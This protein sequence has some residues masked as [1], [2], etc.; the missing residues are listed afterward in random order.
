MVNIT[1]ILD[2]RDSPWV[3][4]P[5]RTVI[6]CAEDIDKEKFR[7]IVGAFDNGKTE[8]TPYE[9]EARRRGLDVARIHEKRSFDLG[10]LKKVIDVVRYRGV[11]IIHTHDFRSNVLGILA[12][13]VTRRSVVT[14]VHGWI[15]NNIKARV[16]AAFDKLLLRHFDHIIAVSE[17]TMN[18]IG[19]LS[20]QRCTIIHNSLRLQNYKLL[21]PYGKFREEFKLGENEV[22]IAHIGR[23]SREKGQRLFLETA[24]EISRKTF[25][26]RFILFGVGPDREELERIVNNSELKKAVLFAG[27]RNDMHLIY[28]DIDLVVQ[29]SYTEGMPNVILESLLME[30]PVIATNVGGTVEVVKHGETGILIEP[31]NLNNIIENITLFIQDRS[32]YSDMAR[33]GRLDIIHRF[34]HEIRV[35]RLMEVYESIVVNKSN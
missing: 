35:K 3:D 23:L 11:D 25:G 32:R 24:R 33:R 27:Y 14:T 18:Q 6:E 7:I 1:K 22:V 19:E 12:A 13:K 26:V 28:N 10:V 16:F 31:N 4:G 8:G 5:G 17:N 29:T 30:V 21:R 34:D 9:Q 2:L 20:G 15:V